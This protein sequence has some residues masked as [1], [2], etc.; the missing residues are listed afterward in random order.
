MSA[1]LWVL[2]WKEQLRPTLAHVDVPLSP[3]GETLSFP[4]RVAPAPSLTSLG[5]T[6]GLIAALC[7]GPLVRAS[8][9]TPGP[10]LRLCDKL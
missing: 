3:L 2:L 10:P 7:S 9:F 5:R 8:V 1:F 4:P 6:L